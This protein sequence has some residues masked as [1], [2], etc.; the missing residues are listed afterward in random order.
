MITLPPMTLVPALSFRR[1]PVILRYLILAA[2]LLTIFIYIKKLAHSVKRQSSD[3]TSYNQPPFRW[4]IAN[5]KISPHP[6]DELIKDAENTFQSL[7]VKRS[8]DLKTTAAEYRKRRG[9]HPPPGFDKWYTF[10]KANHAVIVEDF[11]DQIYHDLAPFW[12]ME[13]SVM[14]ERAVSFEMTI[15]IRNHKA[16]AESNWFWT[17]I[18]LD[19]IQTI[20]HLLP[21]MDIALNAMDEPRIVVPWEKV[22]EYMKVERKKRRMPAAESIISEFGSL[23]APGKKKQDNVVWESRDNGSYWPIAIRGCHPDSLARNSVV[24]TDFDHSPIISLENTIPHSYKG[25]V[26]NYSGSA[27]FCNQP[28]LQGLHGMMIKP[29][30]V[31]STQEF[32]PMFGGSKLRT[33]NEILLPAP[34]YW[35]NDDRYS[36]GYNHGVPWEEKID[37]AI[38]RGVATGGRNRPDNWKGFQRHRFV[39]MTN[40]SKISSAEHWRIIPENWALPSSQHGLAAQAEARLGEWT[41]EWADT[42]FVDLKC[43]T[44]EEFQTQEDLDSEKYRTCYYTSPYF[45]ILPGMMMADQFYRKYLPD[46]DGNSFSGRYRGFLL[47]TSLPIKATMFHEWHDSRLVPWKHFVPM[48]NRFMDFWGIIQ[49]F[50][51]YEGINFKVHGHDEEAKRI[52]MDG[53]SWANKVLRTEDM[54]IYVLRL[55]LEYARLSDDRR[56]SMGWVGDLT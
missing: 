55:L 54:Q 32:F 51:G 12:G 7:L 45:S 40:G 47:S 46:I 48:D 27:D 22:N 28:D 24:L 39:A 1:I 25:F 26:H 5:P 41:N 2:G 31:S 44:Q 20:Q 13:P 49:Y 10:A 14:R 35:S 8:H 50:L 42:G 4:T 43:D 19:L 30:T 38:W 37:Y 18:W 34:I 3:G 6:I 11:F 56:D 9:R 23:K 33:N 36:G 21:D 15:N 16:S 29:L 53:Q 52:A 17:Q